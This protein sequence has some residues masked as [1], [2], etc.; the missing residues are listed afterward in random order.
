MYTLLMMLASLFW[1]ASLF[2]TK[3]ALQDSP[4]TSFIFSRFVVATISMLPILIFYPL[5]LNRSTFKQ[6]I[7]LGILQ[8][9]I[10][11]LQTIG[12]ETISASLSGFISGFYIVF[13]LIIHFILHKQK[14]SIVDIMASLICLGGLG[15][16]THSFE[17]T[18]IWGVIYT[19]GSALLVAAYIYALEAYSRDFNS[20]T[21][22]FLQML[23]LA[24][25]AG[26][27]LLFPGNPLQIPSNLPTWVAIL[28]CGICGSS[29]SFWLHN[30]AQRKL[31]AFKVSIILMLEPVFSAIFAYF[32]L[33]EKLYTTSYIGIA[34]ILV[35]ITVINLRLKKV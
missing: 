16:L 15:L 26:F 13:I 30:K 12:L 4:S 2:F 22:T 31:G 9:G 33:G 20:I 34:M 24:G 5:S 27:L 23:S 8:I 25:F 21:L 14:P 6:G 29:I 10:M 1:G 32:G 28:F 7:M 19:L 11:F 17:A 35:S 18:D 3:L